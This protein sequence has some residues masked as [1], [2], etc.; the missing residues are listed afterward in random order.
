MESI[1]IIKNLAIILVSAKFFGLVAR[2]FQA[3]Q[4]VGELLAG[5]I[6]GPS[7]LNLFSG[8]EFWTGMA[9][10]GVVLLMFSAG[11][12][13]DIDSLKKTGKNAVLLA[14]AGVLVPLVLGTLLYTSFYGFSGFGTSGFMEAIFIGT[15]LT[16]TSVS[17]TVQVL[18]EFGKLSTEVGTTIMSAAIIDDIIGIVVL[19][20]VLGLKDPSVSLQLI[21]FKTLAFFV[22][23]AVV[24]FAIFKLMEYFNKRWPHTR[25]MPII[26]ISL[27]FI[28]A[29]V[30]EEMFGVANITGAYVAGII[31][32]S[33][34]DSEYIESKI[35]ISSYMIFGPIF[36]CSVGL[37][38]NLRDIDASILTFTLTFV[39]V[40]LL[41]KIIGCGLM[42]RSLKFNKSDSLKIGVGMMNRGEVALIMAQR[43]LAA[44][45][46]DSK[47]L[48]PVIILIVV[49][50]IL[51]PIIL[52]AIYAADDKKALA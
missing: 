1:D 44:G 49:S 21:L 43:G 27:A 13:T 5:L 36:F 11:L 35:D 50:A 15:I 2:K 26:G 22:L 6:I 41:A 31:L 52:K 12:E 39:V 8:N 23:A 19:T 3:P 29:Y 48:T 46:I 51:T 17:I 47:F 45:F 9:E 4:V 34:P 32:S 28:M 42:A 7:V 25:R 24:G 10:I 38:T 30:A 33:L 18:K 20:A 37:Q 16:A 14:L 40:A